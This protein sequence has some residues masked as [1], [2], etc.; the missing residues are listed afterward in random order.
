MTNLGDAAASSLAVP[1]PQGLLSLGSKE[2]LE[3]QKQKPGKGN[4]SA[5]CT[6]SKGKVKLADTKLREIDELAQKLAGA[7]DL[8]LDSDLL[9]GC[10]GRL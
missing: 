6:Q 9:K 1:R 2:N 5:L 4:D 7:K 3:K 10:L 8:S